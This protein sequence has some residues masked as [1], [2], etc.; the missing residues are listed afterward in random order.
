MSII[1]IIAVAAALAIGILAGYI[2]RK[3]VGEKAIG[4]AE[5]KAK[6]IVL[7]AEAQSETIKKE[8]ALKAQEEAIR[9]K[10]E[11]EKEIKNEGMKSPKQNGE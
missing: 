3:N 10:N 2:I 5:T 9:Y 6:N 4:S 1:S 7:D 11:A 8:V